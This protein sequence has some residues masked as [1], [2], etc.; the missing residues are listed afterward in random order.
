M[1]STEKFEAFRLARVGDYRDENAENKG[2]GVEEANNARATGTIFADKDRYNEN[3]FTGRWD[4]ET[5]GIFTMSSRPR[6]EAVSAGAKD[7]RSICTRRGERKW[8][9]T[10]VPRESIYP[11]YTARSWQ[12][13]PWDG[14][15]Y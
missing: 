10:M 2:R 12:V 4:L 1:A 5:R 9:N 6:F 15:T 11:N 8:V 3:E 7:L 14:P 13:G